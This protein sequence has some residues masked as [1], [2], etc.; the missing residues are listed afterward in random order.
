MIFVNE[1]L[2]KSL[3]TYSDDICFV[4]KNDLDQHVRFFLAE[5]P[6]KSQVSGLF[7]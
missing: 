5:K 6:L 1:L 4:M 7:E 3:C 2:V